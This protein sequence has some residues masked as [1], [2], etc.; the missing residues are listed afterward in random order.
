MILT[1]TCN[2]EEYAA[3]EARAKEL[4]I[5]VTATPGFIYKKGNWIVGGTQEDEA[6]FNERIH[7]ESLSPKSFLLSLKKDASPIHSLAVICEQEAEVD[8]VIEHFQGK[9]YTELER[10][11]DTGLAVFI[12]P[13]EK[14]VM[15]TYKYIARQNEKDGYTVIDFETFK[16]I[17]L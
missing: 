16:T 10:R 11:I 8:A 5:Q 4:G 9:G 1:T 6:H 15:V 3:I 13:A 17:A 12:I 7:S 14:T 2:A